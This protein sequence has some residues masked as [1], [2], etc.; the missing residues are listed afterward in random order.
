MEGK[1]VV[2]HAYGHYLANG[3]TVRDFLEMTDD[4]VQL[5]YVVMESERLRDLN[6]LLESLGK[7]LGAEK[8]N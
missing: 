1:A 6:N 5:M 7:M 8:V 2:L 3:G 4:D